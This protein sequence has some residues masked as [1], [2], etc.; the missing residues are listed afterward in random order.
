MPNQEYINPLLIIGM[1]IALTEVVVVYAISKTQGEVQKKLTTF[2][3]SFPILIATTFFL[4]LWFKPSNLYSPRDFHSDESYLSL[5]NV[6]SNN[7][8]RDALQ[9]ELNKN[10]ATDSLITIDLSE[11]DQKNKA[12]IYRYSMFNTFQELLNEIYFTVNS[13]DELINPFSYGVEWQLVDKNDGMKVKHIR[14]SITL[15]SEESIRDNRSLKEA[16]IEP[17]TQLQLIKLIS[18]NK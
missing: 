15:K 6:K 5:Q 2:V 8:I 17:G 9:Q 16:G 1:F 4:F 14:E 13:S 11:F 3:V 10:R 7:I 12:L 18:V